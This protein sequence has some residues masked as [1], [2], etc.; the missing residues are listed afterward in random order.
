MQDGAESGLEPTVYSP[1]SLSDTA[2]K[3]PFSFCYSTFSS[4]SKGY[5]LKNQEQQKENKI[6]GKICSK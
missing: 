4:L 2:L 6:L 3:M 5:P 1:K